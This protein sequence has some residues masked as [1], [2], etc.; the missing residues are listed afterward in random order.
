[1]HALTRRSFKV[2]SIGEDLP[3]VDYVKS[4]L[5]RGLSE[6][7]PATVFNDGHLVIVGSGPSVVSHLDEIKQERANGRPICAVKGTHDWLIENG[8]EPDM[9]VSLEPRQRPFKHT[10][11]RTTYFVASRC[12][13]ELFDQLKDREVIIWH[14]AAS[15]PVDVAP[16]PDK[17][18]LQWDELHLTE[19]C[20]P[21]RGRFGVGGGT[22]SGLRA[23]TLGFLL[24][25]RKFILYGMDSCLAKDKFTKRFTGENIGVGKLVD[26][27]VG[28]RQFW[29]NGSMAQQAL[30]FQEMYKLPNISIEAKGDGLLA[31]IIAERKKRGY[32]S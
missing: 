32:H 10:S 1:M 29:C 11:A 4:S 22:T 23:I 13:P 25:F 3:T 20:E 6:F 27:I 16:A 17:T 26:I 15:K 18:E 12:P 5:A 21:W 28:G 8:L 24:G 2:G 31:A 14:A 30:E 19:E 9:F 7:Q